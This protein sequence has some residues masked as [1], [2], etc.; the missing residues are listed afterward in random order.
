MEIYRLIQRSNDFI[1]AGVL[2][3]EHVRCVCTPLPVFVTSDVTI[4]RH[5]SSWCLVTSLSS[6]VPADCRLLS[7]SD[8]LVDESSLTGEPEPRMK[9]TIALPDITEDSPIS[10]KY[11]LVF[12]GSL[13]YS[14]TGVA[15]VT[16]TGPQSEFGKTF[17]EMKD[18]YIS[19][20]ISIDVYRSI[21]TVSTIFIIADRNV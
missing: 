10:E 13:V 11:N 6:V 16:A 20:I 1:T 19:I 15:I 14:G 9:T 12:L 4:R 2:R 8:L 18:D 17:Q 5:L 7:S 21:C 3:S